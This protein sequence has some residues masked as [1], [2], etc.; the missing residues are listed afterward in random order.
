MCIAA[1]KIS[2]NSNRTYSVYFVRDQYMVG[3]GQSFSLLR[4]AL[5][6]VKKEIGDDIITMHVQAPASY[7]TDDIYF[8]KK[9][10]C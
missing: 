5:E 4:D 8:A 1:G 9:G 3:G 10:C 2:Q 6:F 7:I